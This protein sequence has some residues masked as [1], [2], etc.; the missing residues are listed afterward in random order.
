MCVIYISVG[1]PT[2]GIFDSAVISLS[3]AI[4][5]LNLALYAG[6]SKQ[7]RARLASVG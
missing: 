2:L 4:H 7:G 3:L 1:V 5:N 6:S